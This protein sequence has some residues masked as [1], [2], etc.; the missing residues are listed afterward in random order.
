M[1]LTPVLLSVSVHDPETCWSVS[2]SRTGNESFL[3]IRG[4]S[5]G[6]YGDSQQIV[7]E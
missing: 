2:S 5:T 6:T 4:P 3:W 1:K 7:A